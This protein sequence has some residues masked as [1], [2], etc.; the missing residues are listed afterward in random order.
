MPPEAPS[1]K[2]STSSSGWSTRRIVVALF[3][4]GL[5]VVVTYNAITQFADQP[6]MEVPH[7]D[8]VHYVPKD[9]DEDVPMSDFPSQKPAPNER[10]LPD[11]RVVQ[12]GPPQE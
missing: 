5:I 9:R 11:G 3:F 10:I 1:P 2:Q 12:T 8:H 6:Y 4:V 7:G